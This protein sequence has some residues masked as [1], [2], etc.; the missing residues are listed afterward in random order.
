MPSNLFVIQNAES[1][2]FECSFGRGCEGICC[3]NGRPAIGPED[4]RR[5]DRALPAVLP[6]LRPESRKLVERAGY[7]SRRHKSGMPMLRVARGWCVFF[8]DGCALHK[9]GEAIGNKLAFKPYLCALFPLSRQVESDWYVRQK[10]YRN[11]IWDLPC[12]EPGPNTPM[13]VDTLQ[14]EIALAARLR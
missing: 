7:L 8:N 3:R 4:A 1:A 6:L 12:L 2:R 5:I 10:G 14:G 9:A 13:A 11:E